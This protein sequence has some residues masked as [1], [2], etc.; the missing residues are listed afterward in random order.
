MRKL[1]LMPVAALLLMTT[2]ALALSDKPY[3]T[4]ADIDI[5]SL[6]PSPPTEKSAAGQLDI[7]TVKSLQ[8]N[9]TAERAK[10]IRD[11]LPQDVSTSPAPCS[12]LPLRKTR[13]R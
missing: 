13:F 5:A 8:Q 9:M 1:A 7:Q 2:S 3:I 6:L 4:Q 10:A 11:D 12:D